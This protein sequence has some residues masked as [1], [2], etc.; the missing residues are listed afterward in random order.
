MDCIS[1][2]VDDVLRVT[3]RGKCTFSDYTH[4]KEI[5]D[6][7]ETQ[8]VK[9]VEVDMGQLDYIDSSGLGMLLMLNEKTAGR[10]VV[11]LTSPQGQVKKMLDIARLGN[12]FTIV[13]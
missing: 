12:I 9:V 3:M 4:F 10:A 11:R 7:I 5:V 2:R 1:K 13:V 8:P 6:I